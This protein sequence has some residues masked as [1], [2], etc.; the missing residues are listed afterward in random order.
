MFAR[1]PASSAG[2]RRGD[3]IGCHTNMR[4]KQSVDRI[5]LFIAGLLVVGGYVIFTSASFGLLLKEGGLFA[6]TALTQFASIAL[7]LVCC[8]IAARIPLSFVKKYAWVIGIAA[9]I[10]MVLLLIPDIGVSYGGAQRWFSLFGVSVQPGEIFK[11]AFV[12]VLAAWLAQGNAAREIHHRKTFLIFFLFLIVAGALFLSQPDTDSFA[13]V[14]AAGAALYAVG[15]YPMKHLLT[16]GIVGL[17]GATVLFSVRPYLLERL[18]VFINPDRDPLG[19]SYQLQQSLIAIGSGGLTG[20]G[21]GRSVQKFDRLPEPTSDSIF[22]VFGE[23]F[24]L[25]G[26]LL[27]V[28]LF[29]GLAFRGL[30]ISARAPDA[31]ERLLALGCTTLITGAAFLN[32]SSM[33][34]LFPLS[35]L[36]L[37][38]ISHGG[39][40][41]IAALI[42]VG[43]ILNVSRHLK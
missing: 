23:E 35:G 26:T 29:T 5:F 32:F 8:A 10:P 24:G 38:L 43:L 1:H 17:I 2:R 18:T 3:N 19:A 20:K 37:P 36:T 30:R 31:F 33:L 40:A 15:G 9:T 39:T 34:G 13:I 14:I 28:L 42:E 21:F 4:R 22:A 27:L 25:I 41:M 12:I 16:L 6:S 11:L 7:G